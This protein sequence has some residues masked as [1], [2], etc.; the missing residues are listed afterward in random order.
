LTTPVDSN[1]PSPPGRSVLAS[2][3]CGIVWFSMT[4]VTIRAADEGW[5]LKNVTITLALLA[6]NATLLRIGGS[7][8][9]DA[10]WTS[11]V[12]FAAMIGWGWYDHTYDPGWLGLGVFLGAMLILAFIVRLIQPRPT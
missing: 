5:T 11:T 8:W 3:A 1:R 9:R 7:D 12:V 6:S 10:V 4:Q 2:F